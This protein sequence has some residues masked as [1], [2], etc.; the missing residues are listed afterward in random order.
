[1]EEPYRVCEGCHKEKPLSDFCDGYRFLKRPRPGRKFHCNE[2]RLNMSRLCA[3][4]GKR[5]LLAVE[6]QL[7]QIRNAH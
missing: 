1:M 5:G 3:Y 4:G 2:C 6:R 7:R